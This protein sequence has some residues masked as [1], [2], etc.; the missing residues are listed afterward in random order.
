ML[1]ISSRAVWLVDRSRY[2]IK[3]SSSG[4]A[5]GPTKDCCRV[6]VVLAGV[7]AVGLVAKER[8]EAVSAV[9]FAGS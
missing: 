5:D 1:A 6:G 7:S 8:V 4:K 9:V 2:E 3:V